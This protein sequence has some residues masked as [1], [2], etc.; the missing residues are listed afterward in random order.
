MLSSDANFET[1]SIGG[2]DGGSNLQDPESSVFSVSVWIKPDDPALYDLGTDSPSHVSPNIVQKGLSGTSGGF[3]KLSIAMLT[4]G[5]TRHWFPFCEFKNGATDLN[6]GWDNTAGRFA[7]AVGTSYKVECVK[8][9]A[10]ATVN[11]YTGGSG[12]PVFTKTLSAAA[13]FSIANGNAVSVGHKPTSTD[14]RDV[15]AGALD[16]LNINKG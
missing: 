2:S 12:T 14:P 5:G 1:S 13:D 6:P 16:N 7:M 4:S 15:Y 3:W 11:V 9:G 10:N 8:S